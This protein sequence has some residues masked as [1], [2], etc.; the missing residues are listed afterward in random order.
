MV[1]TFTPDFSLYRSQIRRGYS[2][3][4]KSTPAYVQQNS[5]WKNGIANWDPLPQHED[6]ITASTRGIT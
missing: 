1:S 2:L 6:Q 3:H 4:A 5:R